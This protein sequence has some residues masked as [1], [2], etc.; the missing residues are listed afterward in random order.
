MTKTAVCHAQAW[1]WVQFMSFLWYIQTGQEDTGFLLTEPQ[2]IKKPYWEKTMT[3]IVY[4][5]IQF[6]TIEQH[7]NNGNSAN[8]QDDK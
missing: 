2:R 4:L 1:L 3:G 7:Y 6:T 5:L 8:V